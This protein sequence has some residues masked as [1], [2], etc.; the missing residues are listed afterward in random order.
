MSIKSM[1]SFSLF[2]FLNSN[3]FIFY[4]YLF[5]FFHSPLTYLY[6]SIK[7]QLFPPRFPRE[8]AL[9]LYLSVIL[10]RVFFI[11]VFFSN[12]STSLSSS[13]LFLLL[14]TESTNSRTKPCFS[15]VCEN[16]SLDSSILIHV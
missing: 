12:I 6:Q 11:L 3:N 15:P 5:I 8:S 2:F 4:F 1:L 9:S 16:Q 13:L 10:L 14:V 7:H